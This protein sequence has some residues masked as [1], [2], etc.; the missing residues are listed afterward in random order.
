MRVMTQES[1]HITGQY[2]IKFLRGRVRILVPCVL[3]PCLHTQAYPGSTTHI[4]VLD[5]PWSIWDTLV[6]LVQAYIL[7]GLVYIQC[8]N[9]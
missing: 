5:L 2:K 3:M 7:N 8:N 1:I 4:K 9:Q 6:C